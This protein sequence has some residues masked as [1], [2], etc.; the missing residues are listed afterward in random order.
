MLEVPEELVRL[1]E[2][3]CPFGDAIFQL[4]VRAT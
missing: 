4:L 2:L 1:R 3:G